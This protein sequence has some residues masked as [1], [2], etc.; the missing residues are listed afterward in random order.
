MHCNDGNTTSQN[1][2]CLNCNGVEYTVDFDA[3]DFDTG[4]EKFTVARCEQ[5]GLTQTI[6]VDDDILAKAYS[7]SYY[8]SGS[9]KFLSVLEGI[10]NIGQNQQAKKI[11]N[12]YNSDLQENHAIRVLDIGCG[13]GLLLNALAAMG[14]D[15]LGIERNEFPGNDKLNFKMHIGALA[16]MELKDET[17]D[18][19]VIWHVLEHI[20]GIRML[21]KS[22]AD[23]LRVGGTLVVSVPNYSS[24]QRRL[25]GSHWFHLDIPRHIL[26]FEREWLVNE[27]ESLGFHIDTQSTF[28]LSQNIYGFLQSTFNALTPKS[29][30]RFYTL[31]KHRS[32]G[33]DWLSF[34]GWGSLAIIL[35]PIALVESILAES[36][37]QGAT[38]TLYATH[39][40]KEIVDDK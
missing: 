16:D 26:H 34:F 30:N 9:T 15:G 20:A 35:F 14:A 6:Y 12:S 8:G 22:I 2:Y 33:L 31:L 36:F 37:K 18:I 17:F 10:V 23:H 3:F 11:L 28:S 27:L 19:I 24:W 39:V 13:R 40:K 38:L 4:L 7:A 32:G 1:F 21:L 25:F 5:C 29:P